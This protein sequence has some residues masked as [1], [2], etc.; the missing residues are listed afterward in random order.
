MKSTIHGKEIYYRYQYCYQALRNLVPANGTEFLKN[1][2]L[3]ETNLSVVSQIELL[4]WNASNDE[5]ERR[6]KIFVDESN[7]I[8]LGEG[9]IQKTIE[10][11]RKIKVKLPDAIIAASAIVNDFTLISDNDS[12]FL[13]I[14]HLK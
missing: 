5:L 12:D 10:I 7:I 2:L 14:P 13:R 9:V 4:G 1:A 6:I 11:R 3:S 8:E